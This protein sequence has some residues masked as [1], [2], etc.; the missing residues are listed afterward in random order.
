MKGEVWLLHCQL[1][2]VMFCVRVLPRARL[3]A[4]CLR[5]ESKVFRS[6]VCCCRNWPQFLQ[7]WALIYR[8][9]SYDSY[10]LV[11]VSVCVCLCL[12]ACA[13]AYVCIVTFHLLGSCSLQ[14]TP[15][16][17]LSQECTRTCK[18]KYIHLPTHLQPAPSTTF[19]FLAV[20][21][22]FQQTNIYNHTRQE[23]PFEKNW[24]T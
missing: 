15:A 6:H 16:G 3:F 2:N 10:R 12:Y 24:Q 13:S 9:W 23:I 8:W 22:E 20:H 18:I 5:T 7:Q 11:C 17:H 1:R 14:A 21:T 19:F 4:F